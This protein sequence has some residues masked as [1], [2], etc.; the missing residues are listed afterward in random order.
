MTRQNGPR[1]RRPSLFYRLMMGFVGLFDRWLHLSC[2]AFAGLA[3]ARRERALTRGERFRHRLHRSMCRICRSHE[4]HM[5]QIAALTHEV[6][7][8][9]ESLP[10]A[11]LGE[12]SR[13]RIKMAMRAAQQR[14]DA[15]DR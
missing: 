2:R 10:P 14:V 15:P 4:Q 3:S 1:P 5:D 9:Q 7:R 8:G 6:A 13:E 11:E 12:A